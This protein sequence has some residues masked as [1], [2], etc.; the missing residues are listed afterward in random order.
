MS[1]W[2][3]VITSA[4]VNGTARAVVR[5]PRGVESSGELTREELIEIVERLQRKM[6]LLKVALGITTKAQHKNVVAKFNKG[7]KSARFNADPRAVTEYK[8]VGEEIQRLAARISEL[9]ALRKAAMP[10]SVQWTPE[11]RAAHKALREQAQ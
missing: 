1:T 6:R 11:Q 4:P 8:R 9:K 3:A 7:L 10:P 5:Q 2:D